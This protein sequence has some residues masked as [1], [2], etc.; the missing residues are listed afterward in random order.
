MLT[1]SSNGNPITYSNYI[2]I[3]DTN[4]IEYLNQNVINVTERAGFATFAGSILDNLCLLPQLMEHNQN[5]IT[6]FN[7]Q[8]V[9]RI[10]R[11]H[12]RFRLSHQSLKKLAIVER[13]FRQLG[14]CSSGHC[15]CR[16]L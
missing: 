4:K 1:V 10:N 13:V 2:V 12:N 14:T 8:R 11:F 6:G 3:K 9:I 7:H 16:E 15:R 5:T